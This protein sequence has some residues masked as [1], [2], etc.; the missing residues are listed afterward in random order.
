MLLLKTVSLV[1]KLMETMGIWVGGKVTGITAGIIRS[2]IEET[3]A[4]FAHA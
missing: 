2:R 1:K 4:A 3:G